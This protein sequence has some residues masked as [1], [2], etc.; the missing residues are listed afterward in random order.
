M[1]K[2][3]D[4]WMQAFIEEVNILSPEPLPKKVAWALALSKWVANSE[5]SSAAVAKEWFKA[6]PKPEKR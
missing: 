4:A 3:R 5:R 1:D 2:S 6:R